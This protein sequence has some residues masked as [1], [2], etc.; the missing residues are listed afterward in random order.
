MGFFDDGGKWI[1]KIYVNLVDGAIIIL[2]GI[3]L[4]NGCLEVL[5]LYVYFLFQQRQ[6]WL[7]SV[8][9]GDVTLDVQ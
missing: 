5:D 9:F 6:V 8:F 1:L 4:L 2:F 7:G 3:D